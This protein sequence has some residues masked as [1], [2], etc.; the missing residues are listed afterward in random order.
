V[1]TAVTRALGGALLVVTLTSG[2]AACTD[3][4]SSPAPTP[5]PSTEPTSSPSERVDLLFGVYGTNEEIAAY[6]TMANHFDTVNERADVTVSAW[7][8]HDGLRRAIEQGKPLPDVF[9]VSRRDLRWFVENGLTAPVDTLLDERGV[10]FGDVYSRDALEAF[11]S[12][13]RLQCMPY[14][15]APQVVFYNE[16]MVDFNRMEIR[17]F[18]V[19]ADHRRWSWEQFV[20]AAK[21]AARPFRETK[22]VAIDPTLAGLAPFVYS[23]GGDLFDDDTDPTSLAFS[24]ESTQDAL[25]TILA[26][27]RDPKLT[28]SQ[29]QL[30]EKS[31]L[32]WFEEGKVGMI[33]GTRA[34]VPQLREVRDLRFDVMPIP[35]IEGA[36]TVGEISGLCIS[37]DAESP[38]TAADFMVYA[39]STEAVSEVVREGYLQPA[40]Q[41]VA[42]SDDFLQPDQ[43][44]LNSTVFNEAVG[45]MVIPPLLDTWDELEDAVEPYLL[46][47]FF[48]V[49]TIDLPL[50]G[51]EIDTVSKPILSPE[52]TTPTPETEASDPTQGP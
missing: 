19:P 41:E 44:P 37:Q 5:E 28:L 2:L 50:L 26:V 9:L 34:L 10:D 33:T 1:R 20:T 24:D 16:N 38:A 45:R 15:V 42:L 30:E 35:S 52:T 18:D 4:S 29:E 31:P 27:F 40:N 22:G 21:F 46:E 47:M 48:A 3:E 49:P 25:E 11:S 43:K 17:G 13:N 8:N 23:G 51:A 36:A 7:Q 14:G 32:E 12:D 6:Q 39:S